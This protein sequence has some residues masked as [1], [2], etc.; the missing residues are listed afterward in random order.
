M[1]PVFCLL[2]V[3]IWAVVDARSFITRSEDLCSREAVSRCMINLPTST[4]DIDFCGNAAGALNCFSELL[5]LC[6]TSSDPGFLEALGMYDI[7][8]LHQTMTT[9]CG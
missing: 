5:R 4:S 8:G 2:L 3:S 6:Y 9:R 1:S 7:P